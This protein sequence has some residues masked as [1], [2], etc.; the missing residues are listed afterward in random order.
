MDAVG[1]LHS[2]GITANQCGIPDEK[3]VGQFSKTRTYIN[4]IEATEE[5]LLDLE[6]NLKAGVERAFGKCYNGVIYFK[7]I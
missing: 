2:L 7:T 4:G 5:D 3:F 6:R 1:Y